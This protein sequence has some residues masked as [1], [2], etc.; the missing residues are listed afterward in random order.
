MIPGIINLNIEA[1]HGNDSDLDEGC[2]NIRLS[3]PPPVPKRHHSY[4]R[5]TGAADKFG[6]PNDSTTDDPDDSNEEDESSEEESSDEEEDSDF[7]SDLNNSESLTECEFTD[8]EG[9][10]NPFHKHIEVPKIVIEAG[11]PAV[12]EFDRVAPAGQRVYPTSDTDDD[13]ED[14]DNDADMISDSRLQNAVNAKRFQYKTPNLSDRLKSEQLH[15]EMTKISGLSVVGRSTQRAL[16]LKKNWV[17][18]DVSPG[19]AA[20]VISN[21]RENKIKTMTI[22]NSANKENGVVDDKTHQKQP[23]IPSITSLEKETANQ[24]KTTTPLYSSV[25]SYERTV[26]SIYSSMINN[27]RNNMKKSDSSN[28]IIDSRLKSQDDRLSSLQS[29]LKPAA[30]PSAQMEHFL[31]KTTS[32]TSSMNQGGDPTSD[33]KSPPLI[34]ETLSGART[35]N[36]ISQ[37][38]QAVSSSITKDYRPPISSSTSTNSNL[39]TSDISQA[40]TQSKPG[41]AKESLQENKCSDKGISV[42]SSPKEYATGEH[43]ANP[44]SSARLKGEK[45]YTEIERIEVPSLASSNVKKGHDAGSMRSRRRNETSTDVPSKSGQSSEDEDESSNTTSSDSFSDDSESSNECDAKIDFGD[46]GEADQEGLQNQLSGKNLTG[47]SLIGD[48]EA[49]LD[50][51]RQNMVNTSRSATNSFRDHPSSL[52]GNLQNKGTHMLPDILQQVVNEPSDHSNIKK[53]IL[54]PTDPNVQP[55]HVSDPPPKPSRTFATPSTLSQYK[56]SYVNNN[57]T[58][59]DIRNQNHNNSSTSSHELYLS[60]LDNNTSG[61]ADESA[62]QNNQNT[63]TSGKDNRDNERNYTRRSVSQDPKSYYTPPMDNT[64]SNI[65]PSTTKMVSNCFEGSPL[66][67]SSPKDTYMESAKPDQFN[68][69]PTVPPRRSS[70]SNAIAAGNEP[71]RKSEAVKLTEDEVTK[72]YQERNPLERLAKLNSLKTKEQSLVHDMI[73]SR[74]TRG[75]STGRSAPGSRRTRVPISPTLGPA[76]PIPSPPP[77]TYSET[78]ISSKGTSRASVKDQ[79]VHTAI[80]HRGTNDSFK[81]SN[82]TS[83]NMGQDFPLIDEEDMDGHLDTGSSR[84]SALS[85]PLRKHHASNANNKLNLNEDVTSDAKNRALS[86]KDTNIESNKS[87]VSRTGSNPIQLPATPLTD[88]AK[89]GIPVRRTSKEASNKQSEIKSKKAKSKEPTLASPDE[90]TNNPSLP[91]S[92]SKYSSHS[93]TSSSSMSG[94]NKSNISPSSNTSGGLNGKKTF[95]QTISGIFKGGST[96]SNAQVPRTL[97]SPEE[98]SSSSLLSNDTSAVQSNSVGSNSGLNMPTKNMESN[99]TSNINDRKSRSDTL[100]RF[101][102]GLRSSSARPNQNAKQNAPVGHDANKSSNTAS[103][104]SLTSNCQDN[105]AASSPSR[106]PTSFRAAS[107]SMRVSHPSTPPIPLSRKITIGTSGSPLK[108]KQSPNSQ[109]DSNSDLDAEADDF[110]TSESAES[111]SL[112]VGMAFAKDSPKDANVKQDFVSS[113]KSAEG[114]TQRPSFKGN[115]TVLPPEILE[116]LMRRGGKT[117]K[118]AAKLAQLKRIREAQEIQRE[119]EELDVKHKELEKRGI[120]AERSL[121]GEDILD[122]EEFA[123]D[124]EDSA[125]NSDDEKENSDNPVT[126]QVWFSLLAEKNSLVRKEQELLVQAKML[127][128]E[129]RSSR[130]ETELRDQHLLL[131]RPPSNNEHNFSNQDKKNVAREGQILA[132]LL[133]ISEQREL[134]HSMLTKDRARYQQEDMAIEEQMKASGLR[135]K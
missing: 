100:I 109:I 117:A 130:L 78:P 66:A 64:R 112:N 111:S 15:E 23:S 86:N 87:S 17:S 88:P 104:K 43:R 83:N 74:S 53:N 91:N 33:I 47:D 60:C 55:S 35:T 80:P 48:E 11:S 123:K 132:E 128:L 92:P 129:D 121:R 94:G 107:L 6:N 68:N 45:E 46:E 105:V 32:V 28:P 118:R 52:K 42:D 57:T 39:T 38:D 49:F 90:K 70:F 51:Q 89:F 21:N 4:R 108:Q 56:D 82:S 59:M 85:T 95:M 125:I 97:A 13:D 3:V 65:P 122:D 79:N 67:A 18:T 126:I 12:R 14:Q 119:L 58:G 73:L 8:S 16:N 2:A 10:P 44:Q 62:T 71:A 99:D 134:L 5:Q 7:D 9:R 81:A 63:S 61:E 69:P 72:I 77:N 114:R 37:S 31:K 127:E 98:D 30:K 102:K 116:K 25:K 40:A 120:K 34:L 113:T 103:T 106:H 124:Y 133:E 24:Q 54:V 96:A 50:V 29:L 75:G 1:G 101:A 27:S 84:S 131:D 20:S 22:N 76:P 93:T 41:R 19:L 110:E 135:V 26:P 36:S 115:S